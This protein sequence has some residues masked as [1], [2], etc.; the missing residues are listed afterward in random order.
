MI[1]FVDLGDQ[2]ENGYPEF[3]F[4]DTVTDKFSDFGGVQ[5]FKDNRA[6]CEIV[7]DPN[8]CFI[9]VSPDFNENHVVRCMALIPDKFCVKYTTQYNNDP[10]AGM[11]TEALREAPA[12][13]KRILVEEINKLRDK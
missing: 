6:F 2:L 9:H 5:T 1:R 7:L 3:A 4:F 12:E 13:Q 10:A 11:I 8:S